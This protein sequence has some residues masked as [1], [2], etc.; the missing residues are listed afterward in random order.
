MK[1]LRERHE[2]EIIEFQESCPHSEISDWMP[3]MWAPGHYSHDVRICIRCE[4]TLEMKG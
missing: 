4:K 3:Y 2:K 1:E